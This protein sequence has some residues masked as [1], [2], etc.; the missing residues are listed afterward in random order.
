M[1]FEILKKC[2]INLA[3]DTTHSANSL[4]EV[5]FEILENGFKAFHEIK[6]DSISY[7]L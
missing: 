2:I 4:V 7:I 5:D 3:L 6:Y 1:V